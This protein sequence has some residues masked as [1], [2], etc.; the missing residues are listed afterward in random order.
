[1]LRRQASLGNVPEPRLRGARD[2]LRHDIA[3][4]RDLMLGLRL[5]EIGT[6]D[7]LRLIAELVGR[8]R[9]ESALEV[10]LVSSR[11]HV[12]CPPLLC[13]HIVRI[14]QEALANVRK[15]SGARSVTITLAETAHAGRLTIEDDGRGFRFVGRLTLEQLERVELGPAVIKERVRA[16]GGR[17]TIDSEPRRGVKIEIEWPRN[18]YA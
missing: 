4:V 7:V 9:R 11:S 6:T 12:D 14:V 1:V 13:G 8:L 3:D 18:V 16:M 15:H 5:D 10:R 2:Q 17:L